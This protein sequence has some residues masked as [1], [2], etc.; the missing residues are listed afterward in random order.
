MKDK[1]R[2]N[3]NSLFFILFGLVVLVIFSIFYLF[4]F[5]KKDKGN[6]V[7]IS[8][9][10]PTTTDLD[11]NLANGATVQ[12]YH[13]SFSD[14]FSG[15]AWTD[16]ERTTLSYD[17]VAMSYSYKPNIF[18]EDL[19]D[20]SIRTDD[21]LAIDNSLKTKSCLKGQCLEVKDD[22]LFYNQ[23]EK[24]PAGE[25]KISRFKIKIIGQRW[26]VAGIIS[27]A[28]GDYQPTLWW[29]DGDNFDQI[30]LLLSN[31][32]QP[33]TNYLG[34]FAISGQN[35]Q[36]LVLYSDPFGLAWQINGQEVRDISSYFNSRINNNG[37]NPEII[38]FG[39]GNETIW[40]VFD[41]DQ[42]QVKFLKFWQNGTKWIEGVRSLAEFLPEGVSSLILKLN[43]TNQPEFLAKALLGNQKKLFKIK[44]QGFT[45]L[46]DS[47]FVSK[48]LTT[49]SLNKPNITRA[50]ISNLTGGW[51]G[52]EGQLSLSS[53]NKK[54]KEVNVGQ[55]IVFSQTVNN[56][57]WRLQV[58]ANKNIYSSPCLK[59]INIDYY[60]R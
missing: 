17:S 26:L 16:T 9:F 38:S 21:C 24:F 52:F 50:L 55:E 48:N 18:V 40:Y 5:I 6:S 60:R 46:D 29:F 8:N 12:E 33:K 57:W 43:S 15:V 58:K 2:K 11:L 25:E 19:G 28:N 23:Q 30:K 10:Q 4:F 47:V 42:K 1:L 59:M 14:I 54:W 27:L 3:K 53:D 20:C 36:V 32:Q 44:D 35:D 39:Q 13:G 56:L 41:R 49:H 22:R 7:I 34:N 45:A 37:F 31:G 51:S